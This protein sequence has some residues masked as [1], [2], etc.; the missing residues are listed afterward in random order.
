M[1]GMVQ[2]LLFLVYL[3][4]ML[5]VEVVAGAHLLLGGLAVLAGVVMVI[6]L[7]HLD[8]LGP[9]ILA[10]VV[11]VVVDHLLLKMV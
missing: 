5:V 3:Q 2:L 11:E 7:E 6:N 1:V 4:R 8:L 9:L 10:V